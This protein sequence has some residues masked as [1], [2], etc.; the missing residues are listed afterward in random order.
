MKPNHMLHWNFQVPEHSSVL[1]QSPLRPVLGASEGEGAIG[2]GGS[3]PEGHETGV[4][5][6][7]AARQ[8]PQQ[9]TGAEEL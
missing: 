3:G 6:A 4:A 2:S 5:S 9:G 1:P 7:G 8:L